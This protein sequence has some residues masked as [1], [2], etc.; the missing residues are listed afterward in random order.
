MSGLVAAAVVGVG[1][2]A[3]SAYETQEAQE[4]AAA[5]QQQADQVAGRMASADAARSRLQQAREA[6]IRNAQLLSA[7]MNSG[8]GVGG[9]GVVGATGSIASQAAGNIGTINQK[10]SFGQE[11]SYYNQQAA[12]ANT[13]AANAQMIG[14]VGG[15]ITG[16]AM[17][18][19]K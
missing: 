13:S 14:K 3:Y 15:T 1:I 18:R 10:Q 11:I 19:I 2:S 17:S 4:D 7:G 6:R 12:D 8:M 9:S 5:A 16:L